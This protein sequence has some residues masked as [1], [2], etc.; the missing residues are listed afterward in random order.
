MIIRQLAVED[1]DA[2]VALWEEAGLSY[3]PNGRDCREKI[4]HEIAGI[5]AIF[6]VA[7]SKERIIGAILGT[8]DGR[9][10]WINRL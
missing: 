10:G 4:A 7:E 2:L 9:K 6:L 1:Y 5:T 8:H 3:R